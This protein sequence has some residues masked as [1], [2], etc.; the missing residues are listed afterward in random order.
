MGRR[1]LL[2]AL[3]REGAETLA[4]IAAGETAEEAR[5]RR[6][7][8]EQSADERQR[9]ERELARC[10]DERRA[11][12]LATA[13]R[14][15]ALI[16]LRAEHLLALR[17]RE[18][19][20]AC[21]GQVCSGGDEGL[22]RRLAGELPELAWGTVTVAEVDRQVAEA[23]FPGV[24][25]TTDP[26]LSGGLRAVSADGSLTV[27]NSL[28]TRLTRLWPDLLPTLMAE[29]RTMP[30]DRTTEGGGEGATAAL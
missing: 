19:A 13:S 14:E 28:E 5:L 21:L 20:Q 16:R 24:T 25:V 26:A 18:R 1:E 27:D 9:H 17:L 15:A 29:L 3:Q 7:A 30:G 12:L 22:F 4:A 2:E 23:C 8:A 10:C 11:A 6:T